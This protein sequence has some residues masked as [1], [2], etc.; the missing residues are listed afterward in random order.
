MSIRSKNQSADFDVV[1]VGG[2]MTGICAAKACARLGVKTALIHARPVLGGNASSEIRVG[3]CGATANHI[4]PDLEET[5]IFQE[6]LLENKR[7]NPD[8]NF[9]VWDAVLYNSVRQ[10][11]NLTVYLNTDMYDCDVQDG[12]ITGITCYQGTTEIHWHIT[13]RIFID[14]TGNLTLGFM[15]GA[16]YTTGREDKATYNEP[17]AQDQ[18][19]NQRMG[20]TL[21]F[22]AVRRDHP[23]PFT[24]PIE[25]Y[26]F[27]EDQLRFRHHGNV[28]SLYSV[29]QHETGSALLDETHQVAGDKA[30][31]KYCLEYGY[32][33][34]EVPGHQDDIISEYEDI[35][36]EVLKCVYG[37]WNHI[38]N[39]GDH[40]ADNYELAW[41]GMLPG[42]RESRRMQALYMLNENDVLSNRVFDDAV[43]YGGWPMDVHVGG[44]FN[45]DNPPSFMYAFP[46]CYTIP[47]R[48]FISRNV[49][50]LLAGGRAL[51]AS[52]LAMSSAR[53]IATCA[54][55][56]QAMGTAAAIA[57]QHG[58]ELSDL[59]AQYIHEV[60]QQLL[61]DDCYLPGFGNED[62]HD[63]A[64]GA[65][66]SASSETPGCE[67]IN[68][69]SGVTR[70]VDGRS[71]V[72]Q[73]AP[74]SE[75]LPSVMLTLPQ[76]HAVAQ[77]QLTLDTNLSR[78]LKIT[79]SPKRQAEQLPGVPPE[80]LRDYDVVL[81]RDGQEVARR[82][83]RENCQRLNRIDFDNVVCDAVRIEIQAT[84]G[85]PAARIY[86]VRVYG[87]EGGQA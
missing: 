50:N 76:A 33:W 6:I 43:A 75:G 18:A 41:V 48:S 45:F 32:W 57:L 65:Q 82:A 24:P 74:L 23:V 7:V 1:V 77:V 15:S 29:D 84:N 34:I 19:D 3:A 9:S 49:P 30:I 59:P 51:G 70:M 8:Y 46:G 53:V 78:P 56:G 21:F 71:N 47:L 22:K 10:E 13:G 67:A 81:L 28:G 25:V 63:L 79:M 80:L 5:G 11:K 85:L 37:I 44:L 61:R 31:E 60:Q 26:H 86:E 64:H 62:P 38:K 40:G 17:H 12:R 69:L 20:N 72:W 4:K 73:S 2:G 87:S 55:G 66:V 14:C 16:D 58:C 35:R 52:K 54:V 68:L 39:E 83:V 42:M 27:T 36:D